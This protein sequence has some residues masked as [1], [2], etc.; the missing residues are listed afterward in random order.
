VPFRAAAEERGFDVPLEWDS[1]AASGSQIYRGW[2]VCQS[3]GRGVSMIPSFE[4]TT[5]PVS[6]P[7]RYFTV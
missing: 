5:C 3:R 2:Q 4:G 6:P 1:E 7:K